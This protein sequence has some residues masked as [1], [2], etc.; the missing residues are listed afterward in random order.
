MS[1]IDYKIIP[2]LKEG[3]RLVFYVDVG[4]MP[5]QKVKDYLE[6]I[7]LEFKKHRGDDRVY[8]IANRN[9]EIT[10]DLVVEKE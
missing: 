10:Q 9:G 1:N 3:E 5:P 4:N 7:G 8:F 6:Q 2:A